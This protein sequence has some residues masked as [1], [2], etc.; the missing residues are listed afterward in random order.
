MCVKPRRMKCSAKKA[1]ECAAPLCK[2]E[3]QEKVELE[4]SNV[5]VRSVESDL[6]TMLECLSNVQSESA[7]SVLKKW[8]EEKSRRM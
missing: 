8:L 6:V 2:E 5:E 1:K 7:K 4:E 3:A